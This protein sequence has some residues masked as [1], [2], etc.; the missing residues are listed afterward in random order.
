MRSNDEE[1]KGSSAEESFSLDLELGTFNKSL[2][3]EVFSAVMT[4]LI[5]K[6][7]S[8]KESV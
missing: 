7:A 6:L 5:G 8:L 3:H 4:N 1:V 2:N